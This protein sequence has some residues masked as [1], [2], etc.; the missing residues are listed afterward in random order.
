M[1]V[2]NRLLGYI[3]E[4]EAS[5]GP[6]VLVT[7]ATGAKIF[8][9]GFNLSWWAQDLT[10]SLTSIAKFQELMN[11]FLTI[12]VPSLAVINGHAYAGGLILALTHDFR[13]MTKTNA[14]ICLSELAVGFNLS[15]A[16]SAIC[17]ATLPIQTFRKLMWGTPFDAT[18][19]LK[20]GVINDVFAA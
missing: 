15:P 4:V 10:N 1:E 20:D 16:Y 5:T 7:I 14:K 19:A 13:I 2:I 12:S 18:E 3:D 11:R 6:A 17:K 9:T 8:S